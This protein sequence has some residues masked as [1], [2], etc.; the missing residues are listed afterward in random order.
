M[1][2]LSRRWSVALIFIATIISFILY[3]LKIL[4]LENLKQWLY[5]WPIVVIYYIVVCL[6]FI[7]YGFSF[8]RSMK[9]GHV[10]RV[11][12]FEQVKDEKDPR[13]RAKIKKNL[14]VRKSFGFV[15]RKGGFIAIRFPDDLRSAEL[16][17]S[18]LP[19]LAD[20]LAK[21]YGFTATTWQT[22]II[23]HVE[24]RVMIFKF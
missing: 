14:A 8:F 11:K 16:L 5:I 13:E 1:R 10:I 12:L 2:Y 21:D 22:I 18:Q 23:N 17:E 24:Y 7:Y 19:G 20:F 6:I 4:S 3:D 9:M 15:G